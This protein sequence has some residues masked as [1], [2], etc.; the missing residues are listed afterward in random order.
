M[1]RGFSGMD[2]EKHREIARKGGKAAQATGKAH[3]FTTE[4]AKE[5]GR[6]GGRARR[7]KTPNAAE[8]A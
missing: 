6:K 8:F 1:G 5:A 3:K 7:R 4:E 2:P